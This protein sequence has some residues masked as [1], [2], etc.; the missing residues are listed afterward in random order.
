MASLFD[1]IGSVRNRL[2]HPRTNRPGDGD[3]LRALC[4]HVKI[5]RAKR[6]N[7]GNPWDLADKKIN[8]QAGKAKYQISDARFGTP[9]AV[10]TSDDA[11]PNHYQRLIPFYAPQ[12]LAWDYGLP[13][14]AGAFFN[15]LDG[16]QHSALRVA[17]YWTGGVPYLEFQPTPQAACQ[18][19]CR[20]VIGQSVDAMSLA[21]PLALGECGDSL[22][23]I[24]AAKSLLEYADWEDSGK[25]NAARRE[26]LWITLS[27]DE[28][29]FDHQFTSDVLVST[30]ST[31]G[32]LWMPE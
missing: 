11:N 26:R 15:N 17:F 23:E 30:G 10:L 16:S 8:V 25:E 2:R 29:L 13:A 32:N 3:C 4:D 12:N 19:L 28:A 31:I 7:T 5:L 21:D 22:A 14:N 20:F 1:R 27:A 18:Y 9:L 6:K 24:R